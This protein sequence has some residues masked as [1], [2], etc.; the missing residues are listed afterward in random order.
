MKCRI[1]DGRSA[2]RRCSRTG[3]QCIFVPRANAASWNLDLAV[4]ASSE[5]RINSEAQQ[6][7]NN[8]VLRRLKRLEDHLGLADIDELFLA[9]ACHTSSGPENE[10]VEDPA[11][12][13]LSF[14][15]QALKACC[16]SSTNPEIWADS[17]V[18]RLWS[19]FHETMLG[20]HFLP[21]KQTFSSPTPVMLAAMLYCSSLRGAA[22]D[23]ALAPDYFSVL[24]NAIAQLCIPS[25]DIGLHPSD[26]KAAEEWGFQ[27]VL[28]IILA[29][30]LREGMSKE[31][32]VW[33]S[34]AYR[35][36]LEHCPPNMEAS[37]LEWQRLLSGLQI[38]DLE[39]ASIHLSCPVIPIV[40]PFPGLRMNP[41]DQIYRLS[42][43]MH[44][45]LTHFTG[46]GLPTI[47]S[48]VSGEVTANT[49]SSHSFSGVDAAVIRDWARQLD[50]WLVEFGARTDEP[51]AERKL[52]F[53]QYV[54]HRVL[55]LSIYL[56][57]RGSDLLSDTTP[58]EQHELLLS[59]RAAVKLQLVDESIWANFDL[60]II[61]W[62]ALIVIQGVEG[63]VGEPDDLENVTAHLLKLRQVPGHNFNIHG[64]LATR[65]EQ[66]VQALHTPVMG[67]A[68]TVETDSDFD[69]TWFI[70]N[71]TSLQSGLDML[72]YNGQTWA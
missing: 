44:T 17:L 1:D 15:I 20:L 39:H 24:C 29:A 41:Q 32:G 58:K 19:M 66:R 62:A 51:E 11:L 57:A 5:L 27:T 3:V 36:I 47:W 40:A 43:M 2:C 23:S 50:D 34:I 63:G 35:L 61:T 42:R 48:G 71:Q 59:A 21:S 72:S 46:R 68:T 38:V 26:P 53:R 37:S 31:T 55:V 9:G 4:L 69:P 56:P 33:I 54:L 12:K 7:I 8:A 64:N 13:T 6:H 45:G 70:F 16:S 10:P 49:D 18:L 52:A 65:L 22:V 67:G 30:L 28:G 14:S 60:V 25:S